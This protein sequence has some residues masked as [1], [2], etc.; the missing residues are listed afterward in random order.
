MGYHCI[1]SHLGI[2]DSHEDGEKHRIQRQMVGLDRSNGG[3]SAIRRAADGLETGSQF[4]GYNTD[5]IV[6]RHKYLTKT[7]CRT[8][9][10]KDTRRYELHLNSY[11][12]G[13]IN[14]QWD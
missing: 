4:Q 10:S 14:T 7:Y 9:L 6:H 2:F 8:N 1:P 11:S 5:G 12:M 3:V 13:K